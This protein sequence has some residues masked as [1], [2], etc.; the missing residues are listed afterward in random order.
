M[1]IKVFT[2]VACICIFASIVNSMHSQTLIGGEHPDIQRARV[3]LV[4]EF[5][6]RFNG[7]TSH[8]DISPQDSSYRKSNILYLIEPPQNNKNK[9]SLYNEA[10]RFADTI[11]KNSVRLD[12]SDCAWIACATCNGLLDGKKIS[13]NV[14][15][16]VEHRKEDMYKWVISKVNGDCFDTTPR[17]TV[18]NIM[19]YPDDHETNFI[20]LGRMTKEQP[21]NVSKFM[22]KQFEYDATSV[23]L[24]FVK[25]GKLKIQHVAELEFVFSQVPGYIFSIRY[26]ERE[27]SKLGWLINRF[28]TISTENKNN[29]LKALN[30]E[31]NKMSSEERATEIA[32]TEIKKG[33]PDQ[34]SFRRPATN[35]VEEIFLLRVAERKILIRDYISLLRKADKKANIKYYQS[36]LLNMFTANSHAYIYSPSKERTT[37]LSIGDFLKKLSSNKID[38][39]SIDKIAVPVWDNTLTKIDGYNEIHLKTKLETFVVAPSHRSENSEQ[40]GMCRKEETEDGIEWI[41]YFGNVY[42]T[43]R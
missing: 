18:N 15:L 19:L 4:D 24:Y 10:V 34:T 40:L 33:Y 37:K 9:D 17:D 30:L 29:F 42:I 20:S 27:S 22:S 35:D 21:F 31:C 25:S 5:L 39:V 16:N 26:F 41:P 13:F 36:K 28:E 3:G 12:Y 38:V 11:I 6:K 23:F 1:Y 2:R 32:T 8:P 14:Y 43:I 7:D